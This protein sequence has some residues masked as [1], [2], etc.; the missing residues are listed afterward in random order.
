MRCPDCGSDQTRVVDSRAGVDAIRRR[1]ECEVCG[2]RFTTFERIERRQL[3]V[4]K[5]NGA[6]EPFLRDKVASGISLACRKRPISGDQIED[7]VDRVVRALED[8][9]EPTIPSSAVGEAV[10]GVLREVDDVAYV[11]FA[12]VYRAFGSVEQF[13]EA[14]APLRTRS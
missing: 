11:R 9:R 2:A 7:M 6:K 3:W 10:M 12:S 4:A 1:R 5:R 8:R 13:I 14:I